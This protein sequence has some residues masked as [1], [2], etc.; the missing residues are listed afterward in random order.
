[1]AQV[2]ENI[3]QRFEGSMDGLLVPW[4]PQ[5]M[6]LSHEVTFKLSAVVFI[7]NQFYRVLDGL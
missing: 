1:M 6:V 3:R 5:Q 7:F 4:A 2:P